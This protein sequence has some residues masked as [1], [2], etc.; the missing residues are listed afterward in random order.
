M[1]S[2]SA[3][4][5]RMASSSSFLVTSSGNPPSSAEKRACAPAWEAS[6]C[7]GAGGSATAMASQAIASS[8]AR[9][10]LTGLPRARSSLARSR[11]RS[12]ALCGA[13]SPDGNGHAPPASTTLASLYPASRRARAHWMSSPPSPTT[14]S[15][16][17][18]RT[19][20]CR[21]SPSSPRAAYTP[22]RSTPGNGSGW[23]TPPVATTTASARI[24]IRAV[25]RR[26][27]RSAALRGGERRGDAGRSA[28]HHRDLLL[29][30]GA[31]N[32]RLRLVRQLPQPRQPAR[33]L[34]RQAAEE[35]RAH[36]QVVVVEP[37]R[38]EEVG[39]AQD[40]RIGSQRRVLPGALHP[41]AQRQAAGE[42]AGH[43]VH[44]QQALPARAGQAERPPRPVELDRPGEG[45]DSRAQERR[46][47]GVPLPSLEAIAVERKPER[48]HYD[49]FHEV[50]EI[51]SMTPFRPF[52]EHSAA[53][54]AATAAAK[55][56]NGAPS[57]AWHRWRSSLALRPRPCSRS[58]RWIPRRIPPTRARC[59]CRRSP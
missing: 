2:T 18:T 28:A 33:H 57:G 45:G 25:G 49:R 8:P 41:Q 55:K 26:T 37:L 31:R 20:E 59:R 32:R 11:G 23:E 35:S 21:A 40:V 15:R 12:G 19:P 47:D 34:Q 17:P 22:G 44:P 7:S 6:S 1:L 9:S 54:S 51:K 36:Q 56:R 14:Q 13:A 4:P 27:A 42:Q 48:T 24:A 30:Q 38:E 5:P 46:G 3:C 52:Q 58:R 10:S 43:A 29:A 50:R 16:S 53:L 39:G